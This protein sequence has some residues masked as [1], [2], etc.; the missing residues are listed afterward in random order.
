MQKLV[1]SQNVVADKD[2]T[3]RRKGL[4]ARKKNRREKRT[5]RQRGRQRDGWR[6]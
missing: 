3:N 6:D 4:S 2:I 1:D 5:Q